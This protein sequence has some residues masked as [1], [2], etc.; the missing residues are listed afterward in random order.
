MPAEIE[1]EGDNL[2][3]SVAKNKLFLKKN[4]IMTINK[5]GT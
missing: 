4:K 2:L 5:K 1:E 3:K